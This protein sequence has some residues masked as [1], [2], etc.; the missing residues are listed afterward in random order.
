MLSSDVAGLDFL[1]GR[2]RNPC[3][4]SVTGSLN[5]I[6]AYNDDV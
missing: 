2:G 5:V 6:P 4:E 3:L 1:T